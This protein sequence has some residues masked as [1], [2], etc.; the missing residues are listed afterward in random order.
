MEARTQEGHAPTNGAE[1]YVVGADGALHTAR[2]YMVAKAQEA[3][4]QKGKVQ[5]ESQQVE[6]LHRGTRW[7]EPRVSFDDLLYFYDVSVWHRRCVALKAMLVGGLGWEVMRGD[8]LIY[9]PQNR[10]GPV[11]DDPALRLLVRP[12]ADPL[13]TLDE[14]M[15]RFL[16]DYYAIGNAHLELARDRRGRIAELYHV[17]GRTV[18]R[19][20]H[21][22][23]YWQVKDNRQ[24]RFSAFAARQQ[25]ARGED[26][27]VQADRNEIVR[28]AEYDPRDDYYGMPGWYAA[29]GVMGLDRTILEFNTALFRNGLMAHFAVVVTGGRLS[30]DGRVAVQRFV[31][32][33]A[34]GV[35]NAGRVL[36]IEDE[37][38]RVKIEFKQLNLDIEQLI[39]REVQDH[40]RDTVI[41]AHGVPPRLL[42]IVTQGQLGATGEVEGQLRTMRESV[43]RPGKRKLETVL[44]VVLGDVSPGVWVRFAE[45]DITSVRD[46]ADFYDRMIE[47]GVFT[48]CEVRARIDGAR[49][50]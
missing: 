8:E 48:A 44:R 45:M 4:A 24:H 31:Q 11:P 7:A 22:D 9:D 38:D 23:G 32:D 5:K 1:V 35:E 14:I 20:S 46:D 36:L 19:D 17:P 13:E 34:Q 18:R 40:F 33:Q 28:M 2:E 21:F 41:A 29:L 49:E 30:A 43:L 16:V 12:N 37:D 42:G 15:Y 27:T 50:L 39:I 3:P 26:V 25:Q 47:R 10:S 6:D